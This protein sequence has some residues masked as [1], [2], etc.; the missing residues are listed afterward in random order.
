MAGSGALDDLVGTIVPSELQYGVRYRVESRL[1]EGSMGV[2]FFGL[3]EAPGGLSPVVLKLVR[4]ELARQSA[5]AAATTV[6]K[7]AVA[8]GRLNE[9]VPPTPFVVRLVDTG[10]LRR[11]G[12]VSV[13][14]AWIAL[15]YVHGGVEGTTL[16]DRV[17]YSVKR[18]GYAFEPD[19]VAHLLRCMRDGLEAIHGV[20]VIHRDLKPNNVLTCG[21]GEAEVFK[22]SDFGLARPEGVEST[23]G[24]VVL[25]TPGY[26]APE[27]LFPGDTPVG[28]Y[29]DVFSLASLVFFVMTG[30]H[31]FDAK[32]AAAALVECREP[33]RKSLLDCHGLCPELRDRPAVCHAIDAALARATAFEAARRPATA[34]DLV[35]SVLPY[36]GGA[37]EDVQPSARLVRSMAA[38]SPMRVSDWSW[39]VRHPPGDDLAIYSAAWDA[40]GHCLAATGSGLAFWNGTAWS[41]IRT[42]GIEALRGTRI[43]RRLRAGHWLVGGS[44]GVLAVFGADGIR[45]VVSSPDPELVFQDASGH[46]PDLLVSVCR[47]PGGPFLLQAMAARRWMKP[48]PLPGV[49]SI[50]DLARLDADRWLVCGRATE[51]GAFAAVYTP[52][53][54]Q[55]D[56]VPTPPSR[57]MLACAS[58]PHREI[59]LIAGADGAT[60]RVERGRVTQSV[61]DG[62]PDLSCAAIDIFDGEWVSG[63]GRLWLKLPERTGWRCVWEDPSWQVPFVS[64]MADVGLVVAMTADGG[65]LEGRARWRA[66]DRFQ[67][68]A[69]SG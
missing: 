53:M 9:R 38:S 14:L 69:P 3:R 36:V 17:E 50:S 62:G 64:L 25:G 56:R 8:L 15:E 4:P 42:E 66:G 34:A 5:G 33:G 59:A 48:L 23:F 27:Q 29:S 41:P 21:F 43:V 24:N 49:A 20:G 16:D 52:M 31:Y 35:A 45:D 32:T 68:G 22:I 61:V 67:S 30:R 51:G 12:G 28:S 2:A 11:L 46:F 26:G 44:A 1:G 10:T 6:L 60:V 57:A 39:T 47:R 40:D 7:E 54:W 13:Q 37:T 18:T 65:I 58:Q 19:R 63:T 55:V